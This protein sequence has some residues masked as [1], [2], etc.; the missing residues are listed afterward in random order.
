MNPAAPKKRALL[1]VY[2]KTGL[3]P[4][5][6]GLAE[7]GFE[8][9][10]SGGTARA[11]AAAGLEVLAVETVTESPEM[12]GG[13]VKTLHP[14]IH[15][16]LLA[17]R[18]DD[19]LGELTARGWAP[20]DLVV[21]NLYPFEQTAQRPGATDAEIIEQIDIG[22]VTLL[23]SAAKN[24]QAVTVICRP[25]AYETVLSALR[26]DGI[27]AAMRR[28]LALAAF[29][30]TAA[31][32]IAISGW[33]GAQ[34]E[35]GAPTDADAPADPL[36]AKLTLQ[37]E[38]AQ[39]LR[40]GENPHQQAALYRWAGDAG[41]FE[42][43]QGKALSHNNLVDL[44]AAWAIPGEFSEPAVAIIKHTTPCGVATADD[45]V[46]AFRAA[47][48]CDPISAFGSIIAVNRPVD[49][50]LVEAIGKLFIEVLVAPSISPDAERWLRRRK[51]NCRVIVPK[52][53]RAPEAI[54]LRSLPGGMLAQTPDRSP[55]PPAWHIATKRAPT[56]EERRALDFA[57][58]AVKHVKS[59][60][61]VFARGT[62]T[63]GIG[64][65]ETNR[66][67]A[68][69]LAA[70]RSGDNARGAVMASDA[71]FPF[72]DGVETAADAGV[73][74]VIQPGGSVRDA[75]VIAAADRLGL[76]MV[77]TGERHFRH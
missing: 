50:D 2:D 8:L 14:A 18:T 61:I 74:A 59:N 4:L 43:L 27:S 33:M 39:M 30:H 54:E 72:A 38:R 73:I 77:F 20:I 16:G 41:A 36:P 69:Y 42:Q 19:H 34:I 56:D 48:A 10:A 68:V 75:E 12:L 21:C 44:A 31:Y 23:R 55:A 1:S 37:L 9:I 17:Q 32:D 64:G 52:S 45:L 28:E 53:E 60:A 3:D 22:G 49:V 58:R 76:A 70:K 62:A 24:H 67:D 6:R 25:D 7:L 63:V 66:V 71:F 51:K 46:G 29:C 11:L 13:R 26:T 40:Y 47:L 57:W 5:G 65:G 35:G 15:A